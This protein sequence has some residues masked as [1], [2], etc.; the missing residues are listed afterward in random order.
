MSWF[1]EWERGGRAERRGPAVRPPLAPPRSPPFPRTRRCPRLAMEAAQAKL[2]K[3]IPKN[4]KDLKVSPY[5]PFPPRVTHPPAPHHPTAKAPSLA[6]RAGVCPDGPGRSAS[7]RVVA[8]P[9]TRSLGP[10]AAL[11]VPP[12]PTPCHPHRSAPSLA[13]VPAHLSLSQG[14]RAAS[15]AAAWMPRPFARRTGGQRSRAHPDDLGPP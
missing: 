15:C 9:T 11:C 2:Q 6:Q 14:T 5:S 12:P 4:R 8:V 1:S 7:Q 10:M 13:S 3:R